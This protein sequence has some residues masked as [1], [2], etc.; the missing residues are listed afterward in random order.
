MG[1]LTPCG[2][3]FSRSAVP[4]ICRSAD[5]PFR[6]S[7]NRADTAIVTARQSRLVDRGGLSIHQPLTRRASPLLRASPARNQTFPS[8]R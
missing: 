3:T 8:Q 2:P 4:P 5:L 7:A 1:S 6:R